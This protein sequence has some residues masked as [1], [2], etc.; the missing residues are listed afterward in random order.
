MQHIMLLFLSTTRT[1]P[2]NK[3]DTHSPRTWWIANYD[4]IGKTKTTNESAVRYLMQQEYGNEL[5]GKPD[6]LFIIAS[7]KVRNETFQV[8]EMAQ[9]ETHFNFF[10]ERMLEVCGI[11][12]SSEDAYE[13]HEKQDVPAI[14]EMTTDIAHRIYSY[15]KSQPDKVIVHVDM[16]GGM[17][18]TNMLLLN[19]MRLLQYEGV[20][21]GHVLYSNLDQSK[22]EGYVEDVSDIFHTLDMIAG[23]EE[24]ARFGSVQAILKYFEN[25]TQRSPELTGLLDAMNGFAEEIKLCH[26]Y[27]FMEAIRVLRKAFDTFRNKHSDWHEFDEGRP[28]SQEQLNDK[29]MLQLEDRLIADYSDLFNVDDDPLSAIEWCIQHDHLQQA[30]TLYVEIMPTYL[31]KI[32]KLL[33][34]SPELQQSVKK[35]CK[36]EKTRYTVPFFFLNHYFSKPEAIWRVPGKEKEQLQTGRGKLQNCIQKDRL[37]KKMRNGQQSPQEIARI[38][39]DYLKDHPSFYLRGGSHL[40]ERLQE[41]LDTFEKERVKVPEPE[42]KD[43]DKK[44]YKRLTDMM[45]DNLQENNAYPLACLLH[46]EHDGKPLMT[47]KLKL[48]E[49]SDILNDY[50]TLK[51]ERNAEDHAKNQTKVFTAT[52]L[53]EYL[54]KVIKNLRAIH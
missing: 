17:R 14:M 5:I 6:R 26:Q 19:I 36:D 47:I 12:V 25:R 13:Y 9:P 30:L 53:K 40:S 21:I 42:R 7:D 35:L 34:L 44:F 32:R 11:H 1:V 18:H 37:W 49:L 52:E 15:V 28:F 3:K 22:M 10:C 4:G 50:H 8:E 48:P 2:K 54:G 41:E 46:L 27:Q 29:L 23:A 20:E 45:K 39:L 31:I 51:Q 33:V 16:T 24:F 43:A 38:I